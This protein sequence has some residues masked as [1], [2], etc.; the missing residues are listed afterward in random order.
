MLITLLLSRCQIYLVVI[1][2]IWIFFVVCSTTLPKIST[3]HGQGGSK[4]IFRHL[5]SIFYFTRSYW[6]NQPRDLGTFGNYDIMWSTTLVLS[7][8][9]WLTRV[10]NPVLWCFFKFHTQDDTKGKYF[11]QMNKSLPIFNAHPICLHGIT[12]SE[13]GVAISPHTQVQRL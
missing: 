11:I 5:G 1:C 6:T 7:S 12:S 10:A 3:C 9:W 8:P 4:N 2:L 13:Y